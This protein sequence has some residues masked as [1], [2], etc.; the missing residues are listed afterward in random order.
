MQISAPYFIRKRIL[1]RPSSVPIFQ[2]IYRE[3]HTY[4]GAIPIRIGSLVISKAVRMTSFSR[5]MKRKPPQLR[6]EKFLSEVFTTSCPE[7][8]VL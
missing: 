5:N 2:H 6:R 4:S 8:V 1:A 3:T 7:Q